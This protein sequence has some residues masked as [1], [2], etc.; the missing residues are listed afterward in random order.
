MADPRQQATAG[1]IGL[2][3][4]PDESL[5]PDRA[6][7]PPPRR[8]RIAWPAGTM[9]HGLASSEQGS[10]SESASGTRDGTVFIL[11]RYT[12]G[13]DTSGVRQAPR[14][15]KRTVIPICSRLRMVGRERT[16]TRNRLLQAMSG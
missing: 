1:G 13:F 16:A 3:K 4:T 2:S 10:V 6:A 5:R 11:G 12:C 14:R 15:A 7:T 8:P 9:W